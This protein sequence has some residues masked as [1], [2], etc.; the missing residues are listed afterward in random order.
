V[1]YETLS[2]DASNMSDEMNWL[3]YS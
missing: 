2:H 1:K 3:S